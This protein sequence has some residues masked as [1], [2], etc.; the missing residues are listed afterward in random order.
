M[1]DYLKE[2]ALV[3]SV[4]EA[5]HMSINEVE[6]KFTLSQLFIMTTIQSIN[7]RDDEN[8]SS[9]Q[10]NKGTTKEE[11]NKNAFKMLR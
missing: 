4:A 2:F 5:L 3:A 6:E 1:P 7:S 9:K 8:K 10:L 11:R